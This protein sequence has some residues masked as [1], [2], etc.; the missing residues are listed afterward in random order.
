MTNEHPAHGQPSDE[1]NQAT[2]DYLRSV[3]AS[4]GYLPP[5]QTAMVATAFLRPRSDDQTPMPAQRTIA[6]N[7]EQAQ[8]PELA[9]KFNPFL[10]ELGPGDQMI[11]VLLADRPQF[12]VRAQTGLDACLH[13]A[14]VAHNQ[15]IGQNMIIAEGFEPHHHWVLT[16]D[17]EADEI[18][19]PQL[20][21]GLLVPD[22]RNAPATI[23]LIERGMSVLPHPDMI[24][25]PWRA[26]ATSETIMPIS[27][28]T[29]VIAIVTITEGFA[30]GT[31]EPD[32]DGFPTSQYSIPSIAAAIQDALAELPLRGFSLTPLVLSHP[33]E[34]VRVLER[35]IPHTRGLGR[36]HL[37]DWAAAAALA[38]GDQL[39][40][41]AAIVSATT[42]ELADGPTEMGAM[43][44]TAIASTLDWEPILNEI[45]G[46]GLHT[47]WEQEP[48]NTLALGAACA[49]VAHRKGHD[50][51]ATD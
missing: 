20:E 48:E 36:S 49:A 28:N 42:S 1:L 2:G 46:R 25:A 32:G 27:H 21:Q 5:A 15:G 23:D 50:P 40:A 37:L 12:T 18:L 33:R 29:A 45:L 47:L 19:A 30:H 8:D 4:L 22:W 17:V 35:I 51:L 43:L 39:G 3:P 14:E 6:M 41:E 9:A 44:F 16:D 24:G 31:G 13:L 7:L 34:L 38:G 26:Q 11:M 10:A